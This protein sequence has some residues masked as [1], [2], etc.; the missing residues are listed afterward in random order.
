MDCMVLEG[1]LIPGAGALL[2][3]GGVSAML[4]MARFLL[5]EEGS[6]AVASAALF[7]DGAAKVGC[8]VFAVFDASEGVGSV[9]AGGVAAGIVA[10]VAE[11]GDTGG[12]GAVEAPPLS[13]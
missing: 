2:S 13:F 11:A 10:G 3:L 8:D 4:G 6:C 1:V 12:R 7:C 9:E 5:G